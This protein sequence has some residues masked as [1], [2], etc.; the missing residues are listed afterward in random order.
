[1]ASLS[2]TLCLIES[3]RQ[4]HF[5]HSNLSLNQW[6]DVPPFFYHTNEWQEQWLITQE[7]IDFY[8]HFVVKHHKFREDFLCFGS[9][10][11]GQT[12]Q[13]YYASLMLSQNKHVRL[14]FIQN[15]NASYEEFLYS[16]FLEKEL[17][18]QFGSDFKKNV[19][20][21]H[22]FC[23][24][25]NYLFIVII[26]NLPHDQVLKCFELFDFLKAHTHKI[27]LSLVDTQEHFVIIQLRSFQNTLVHTQIHFVS[28]EDIA[29]FGLV[30]YNLCLSIAVC[31][32]IQRFTNGIFGQVDD[33]LKYCILKNANP[34]H[35]NTF[36]SYDAFLAQDYQR[37]LQEYLQQNLHYSRY[38]FLQ[39]I[40]LIISETSSEQSWSRCYDRRLV[41]KI[42][43]NKGGNRIYYF[44]PKN[45]A[46]FKILMQ[47]FNKY[48]SIFLF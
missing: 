3:R 37:Y 40:K 44:K 32:E 22:E 26:D 41:I 42:P 6:T 24:A 36:A 23:L 35:V 5:D 38:D 15:F 17:I 27:V 47:Y 16:F 33:Y 28:L 43:S 21:A 48:T 10:G 9:N 4:H 12:F 29:Q 13:I 34:S 46:A 1:M 7:M 18:D 30:K 20:I 14:V 11:T 31:F 2:S 45:S 19:E 39:I 8:A 25:N